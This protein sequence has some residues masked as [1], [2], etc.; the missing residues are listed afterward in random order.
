MENQKAGKKRGWIK[1][2]FIVT[3][4]LWFS[5]ISYVF[6][7]CSRA[8]EKEMEIVESRKK[9]RKKGGGSRKP[10]VQ[11]SGW[12]NSVYQAKAFLKANL[13][14]P[15]S[16]ES[17]EWGIVREVLPG[18]DGKKLYGATYYTWNKYR[19]KNSY[20]AYVVQTKEFWLDKSGNVL[21]MK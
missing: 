20:G 8:V 3:G 4:V 17:I 21:H 13:K 16:Y 10:I 5:L 12:D 15:D 7:D 19:A 18:L 2:L 9:N 1:W 6:N 14:D 11:N